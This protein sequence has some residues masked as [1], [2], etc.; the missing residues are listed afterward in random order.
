MRDLIVAALR[1]DGA[2]IVE[3]TGGVDLL[4]WAELVACSP[5]RHVFDAIISDIQMPDLTA[6]DVLRKVPGVTRSSP[7]ILITAF[8]DKMVSDDAYNLGARVLLRKPLQIGD[9][10]AVVRSVVRFT[11]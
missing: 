6:L 10:R 8:G 7:V 2:E 3:A 4:E 11:T 9:L 1:Q 5:D